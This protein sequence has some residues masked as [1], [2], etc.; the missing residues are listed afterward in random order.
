MAQFDVHRSIGPLKAAIPFVV[1]VQSG[2]FDVSRRRVVVPLVL[3]SAATQIEPRLNPTFEIEGKTVILNPL[4]LVSVPV[5]RLGE[6]IGSLKIEGDR[7]VGAI[8][9]LISRAWD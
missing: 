7:I 1:V 9:M 6:R 5:D 4:H 3:Q 2:R 8:D